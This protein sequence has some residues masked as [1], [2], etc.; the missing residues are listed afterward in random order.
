MAKKRFYAIKK[1]KNNTRNKIVE[2]WSEC[3]DLVLGYPAEYKGFATKEEAELYLGLKIKV[4]SNDEINRSSTIKKM[5]IKK[6][7]SRNKNSAIL[8]VEISK[9]L[10]NDFSDRCSS[11]EISENDIIVNLIKEWLL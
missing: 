4:T 10:Y 7:K 11:L 9:D 2:T 6:R 3:S 1:G 5:K 8:D